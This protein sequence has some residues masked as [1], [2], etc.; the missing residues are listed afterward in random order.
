LLIIDS[1][2]TVSV[3]KVPI[4]ILTHPIRGRA[5]LIYKLGMICKFEIYA[6][7]FF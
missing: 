5:L 1:N 7:I 3:T 6:L 2:N 4:T